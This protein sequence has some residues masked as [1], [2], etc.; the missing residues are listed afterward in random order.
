M[1]SDPSSAT[2]GNYLTADQYRA[3][4]APDAAEKPVV[5]A[6]ALPAKGE[7]TGREVGVVLRK[8]LAQVRFGQRHPLGESP[9]SVGCGRLSGVF[10]RA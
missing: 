7:R 3:T 10:K 6:Q 5:V 8:V 1:V 4:Y 2:Y 9:D